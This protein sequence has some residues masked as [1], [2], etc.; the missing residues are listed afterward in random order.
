MKGRGGA[1]TTVL[2]AVALA[3]AA[4]G[5]PR[6]ANPQGLA[7]GDVPFGLLD[8]STTAAETAPSVDLEDPGT[9]AVYLVDSRDELL[10]QVARTVSPPAN[11]RDAIEALLADP[12][13]AELASGYGTRI[14]PETQL[15]GIE[16]VATLDLVTID[17]SDNFIALGASELLAFAQVVFT[18]SQVAGV[19]EVLFQVEGEAIEAIGGDGELTAEPLTEADY[20]TVE[21][22]PT[23]TTTTSPPGVD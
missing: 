23:T 19:E 20:N 9:V 14:P 21:P 7:E 6:D 4:C 17:L 12:S 8:P 22:L 16:L 10:V 11:V 2:L 1:G 5:I 13:E 3:V 15:L 18:A